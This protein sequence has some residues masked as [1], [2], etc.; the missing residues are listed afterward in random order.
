[1]IGTG[2]Q[3]VPGGERFL[4]IKAKGGLGNRML[5]ALTGLAV[6]ELTGRIPIIDWRDGMYAPLG[7]N[8]YPLLF[9]AGDMPSP[10][11]LDGRTDVAPAIWAGRLERHP[12]DMICEY[13]PTKHSDPFIYRKYCVDLAR[14][15]ETA[16]VAVFWSYLPKLPRLRRA[17]ARDP[18]FRGKSLDTIA[19]HFIDRFFRP[20]TRVRET[21]A[22][23]FE[24]RDRPVIG[25]H[26]RYTDRKSPLPVIK[27]ELA[28]MR[29]RLPASPIFLATDNGA[30]QKEMKGEFDNIFIIDKFMAESGALHLATEGQDMVT[31]AEN[32]LIDMWALAA[33]DMLIHSRH[34]TFSIAA[35]LIG[36]IPKARQVDVERHN[37]KIV[38]KRFVQN[39]I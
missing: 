18:R 8:A 20:N 27:H 1:M 37:P 32:A 22:A 28:K 33:C 6:A 24:G 29:A 10:D 36:A 17:L 13:H 4:I 34:S 12:V 19:S 31:E 15:D 11:M 35:A 25:V 30:V 5:S 38:F 3:T 39:Y 9:D 14:L 16:P 23:L 26:I 7:V 2:T 21:V